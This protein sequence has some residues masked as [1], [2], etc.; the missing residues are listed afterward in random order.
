[1]IQPS[2]PSFVFRESLIGTFIVLGDGASG[3]GNEKFTK[4]K[5]VRL[6]YFLSEILDLPLSYSLS[7]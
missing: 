7:W 3:M 5:N 1:M 2:E 6:R 4:Q